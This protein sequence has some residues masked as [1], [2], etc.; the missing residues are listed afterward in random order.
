MKAVRLLNKWVKMLSGNSVLHVTQDAG[1]I[2]SKSEVKGY[3]NNLTEKVLNSSVLLDE[4]DLVYNITNEGK[5]VYF[6]IAIFQYGL[7]AY[8]L[9][10]M[11]AET[12]Y[13]QLFLRTVDWAL[14]NQEESG[15]WNTFSIVNIT[16]PYSSMAQ[17]EGAS[18]L[19]RAYMETRDLKYLQAAKQAVDFMCRAIVDGGCTQYSEGKTWF[20]EYIEKPV[21]LNG[22]IFSIWGLYDYYKV[23][24]DIRYKKY[25]D[26][27]V[28]ALEQDLAL[29]ACSYWSKYD[30]DN[31][32]A[33][34]FYHRLHIAQLKVMYEL[35]DCKAFL[36]YADQWDS[37]QHNK[38]YC[39]LAFAVKVFQKL[40]EGKTGEI[41][42]VG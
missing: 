41:V 22:W 24:G 3:Y 35:F 7:G 34:P 40:T 16:P 28:N 6:S 8:D 39:W 30:M 23:S 21:V 29:F 12:K 37:Y 14:A 4:T 5:R 31:K 13:K 42:I 20:K 15:A 9:Y 32:L 1:R 27:A 10:L 26:N 2:Y 18:L 25:L 19:V 33:S 38:I 11:S 36:D 17:G